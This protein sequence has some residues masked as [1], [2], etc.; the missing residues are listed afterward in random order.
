MITDFFNF[1]VK[2]LRRKKLRSSLTILGIVISIAIIFILIGL[3]L[4][5]DNAV[6]EQF[7]MLGTDKFFIMPKGQAGAPGSGGAVELTTK[8][9]NVIEKVSGVKIVSYI[10]AGNAKIEFDKQVRYYI[11]AGIPLD[12]AD[13]FKVLFES[14]DIKA[15]Q[16]RIFEKGD[17][18]VVMLGS[19]YNHGN[20]FEKPVN[21]GSKIKINDKEFK[22]LAIISPIGNPS[23]DQNVYMSLSDFQELFNSGDRVDEIIVQIQEGQSI[24]DVAS[25]VEIK[26][27]K[28]RNVNE[29]T[30][31]FSI[32]TPEELLASFGTIL[33]IITAF[34]VGV[35]AISLVVG[36]VGIMN[37]MYTSVLERTKEIGTMKAVGAKNSDILII[38]LIESGLLGLIGGLIGILLGYGVGK[39]IEYIAVVYVKTNLLQVYFP[40]YI[41][42]SILAFSFLIG[43][44]SGILPA[45][46][47][48]RLKPAEALRYE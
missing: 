46:Q 29:K 19:N 1:A 2:N 13:V 17:K 9:V 48:S 7:R 31:D 26:L 38:F 33:N 14:S 47:A 35:A 22:V 41:T 12:K 5:L 37:T 28:F 43:A 27:R 40:I 36:A 39:L 32:S 25:R 23:D 34:L 24:E 6:K 3:S 42:I 20:L 18:G 15:E 44:F 30:Q 21:A 11:V 10:V 8:D 45:Y 16:G 4:G